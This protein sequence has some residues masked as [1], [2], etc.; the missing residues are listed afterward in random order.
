LNTDGH[1]DVINKRNI[2]PE[3]VGLVDSISISLNSIDPKQ[4][5]ELMRI[6]GER[7][8]RAMVNFAREA[9][10]HIHDVTMTIVD[11]EGVDVERARRFVEEEVGVSFK[12]RPYF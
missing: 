3:L 1:G 2:I 12:L 10:K 6:D 11:I 9:K 4:Y 5:G 8:H 7:F